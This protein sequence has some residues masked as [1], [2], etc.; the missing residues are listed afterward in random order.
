[1]RP[2]LLK[3]MLDLDRRRVPYALCTVVDAK[4]SVPGKPGFAMV[5]TAD[6]AWG[7]VGGAG[8]EERVKRAARDTLATGGT[9]VHRFDLANWK[10]GGLDSVCGGTVDVAVQVVRPRPHLLLVGAGH[11]A[12]AVADAA[13]LLDWRVTVLDDREDMLA[14]DRFPHAEARLAGDPGPVLSKLDLSG[15]SHAYVL[16]YDHHKDTE[17]LVA[18]LASGFDG[19]VG[20]VGSRAKKTSMFQRAAAA[21]A[22]EVRLASVRCPIGLDVGAET[23]EE[24][25]AA[26][27]AEIIALE[28]GKVPT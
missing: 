19:L 26:V 16:G 7:T 12:K 15:Y 2:A 4:G 18:L 27:V 3:V 6:H 24:I 9:K 11:V 10:E 20:V 28:K 8:L 25:A 14:R 23:P 21:G 5:V 22:D 1:M 13:A 17:A